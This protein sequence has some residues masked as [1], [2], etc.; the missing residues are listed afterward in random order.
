MRNHVLAHVRLKARLG[1]DDN[2][3]NTVRLNGCGQL[4]LI[5]AHGNESVDEDP[6]SERKLRWPRA[7]GISIIEVL[8][9]YLQESIS[10]YAHGHM[11]RW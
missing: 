3:K 7:S 10:N 9:V 11:L 6:I 1:D 4:N 2:I 8:Y 5:K